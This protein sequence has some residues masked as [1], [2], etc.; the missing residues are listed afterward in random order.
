MRKKRKWWYT[1]FLVVIGFSFSNW[2][3]FLLIIIST[4]SSSF[5]SLS[6][7]KLIV[8][9]PVFVHSVLQFK[10]NFYIRPKYIKTL[11][12]KYEMMSYNRTEVADDDVV[13]LTL[14]SGGWE[15]VQIEME[16]TYIFSNNKTGQ[17]CDNFE[18]P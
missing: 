16:E 15:K 2:N 14:S 5:S 10:E 9:G 11:N 13:I 6:F 7:H 12:Y 18:S 4:S 8:N 17:Y 3:N 1:C